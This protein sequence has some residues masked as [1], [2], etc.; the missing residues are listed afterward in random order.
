MTEPST[1]ETW[2][3]RKQVPQV[4]VAEHELL[5]LCQ[6]EAWVRIR[7][8]FRHVGWI[9]WATKFTRRDELGADQDA[10]FRASYHED[11]K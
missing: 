2:K 6:V 3:K 5:G 11:A 8:I 10:R 9:S 1:D 7:R 4:L